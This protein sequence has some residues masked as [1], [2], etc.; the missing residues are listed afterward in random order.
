MVFIVILIHRTTALDI[1]LE[2]VWLKSRGFICRGIFECFE[3]VTRLAFERSRVWGALV[4]L[5]DAPHV[6]T[7]KVFTRA[8][9][10]NVLISRCKHQEE[11][12]SSG[13]VTAH[14]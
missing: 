1:G 2:S 10:I 3:M 6:M 4:V 9:V 13:G 8:L 5:T 12:R 14:Q 11:D 7:A